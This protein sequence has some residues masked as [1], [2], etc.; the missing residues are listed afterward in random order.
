[1]L[2]YFENPRDAKFDPPGRVEPSAR[3][4]G[5]RSVPRADAVESAFGALRARWA[6]R[7]RA[8][9]G[10]DAER[11]RRPHGQRLER[12]PVH[13]H[14]QPLALGLVLRVGHRPRHGLPRLAARTCSAS[15]TWCPR[16][17][18]SGSS[19][20]PRRSSQSGGAYHQYQPLTKRGN[21]A[22][23]S[24]FNDD[25]LWLVLAV[26]AYLKETGDRPILDEL[27]PFDNA[28]GHRDA[29][30]RAPRRARS[31]YTLDRLGPHG[32]PLIG[33][34]DWNDCLNLNCFSE[35]PGESFQTTENREGGVAESVF[36]AGLF[37][38]AAERAR[39]D[40]RR[41]AGRFVASPGRR[42]ARWPT[43]CGAHGWDGD[44]V[45]ARLRL[46]R[47]AGRLGARTTRAR[48]SSSP[49]ACASWPA[50]GSTTAAA[51]RAL[52]SVAER[53][54]TPH[55]IVL[56]QPAYPRYHSELGEISSY[57]PGYKENG[58]VFCHTNPWMIDR[59]D[60]ASATATRALDYHLRINPSARE[61]ISE[62]HRCEP[63]VYAQMIAGREAADARRGEELVAHRH[64][65]VE[66]T[67][68]SRSGS[69]ASG[70]STTACASTRA[71]RPRGR[72]S[73]PAAV[74]RR[75][76]R[77]RGAR[78]RV[79]SL[80]WWSTGSRS[81]GTWCRS[82]PPGATVVVEAVAQ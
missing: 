14:V 33:R 45:P 54:A 22:I 10:V 68:R 75:D 50:S 4:A 67:S 42:G 18:A 46:L 61:A 11:A 82:R 56:L 65:G 19:T 32:L 81:T 41:C 26:A 55:G 28:A 78:D 36:I 37:V 31:Q 17:R 48:S 76:L 60:D 24:G 27:V 7:A 53:L 77:D 39:G 25:P 2:G 29:A 66:L 59:R 43:P 35:E 72:G 52:D 64:R 1:M 73:R 62:V 16:G 63:Y 69:S 3:A 38:L 21:D 9:A 5:D 80:R 15:C 40:R 79:G 12:V 34:A 20:S 70:P 49:R 58:S 47:R 57:P 8:A 71:C 51:G 74:P 23:G 44:V 13:G 6:D 30:V